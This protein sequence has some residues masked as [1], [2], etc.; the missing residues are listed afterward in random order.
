MREIAWAERHKR[1][2]REAIATA[3]ADW[4]AQEAIARLMRLDI[5]A[6]QPAEDA[7]WK[8]IGQATAALMVLIEDTLA[9]PYEDVRALDADSAGYGY[10]AGGPDTGDYGVMVATLGEEV[11]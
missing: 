5:T 4:N 10:R 9:E 8:V 1:E 6:I 7:S 3:W 2:A 11:E